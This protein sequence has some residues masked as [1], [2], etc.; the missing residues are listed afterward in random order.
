MKYEISPAWSE[1]LSAI[2]RKERVV[3]GGL[4]ESLVEDLFYLE[5][6]WRSRFLELVANLATS[7][8]WCGQ[9]PTRDEVTAWLGADLGLYQQIRDLLDAWWRPKVDPPLMLDS[10]KL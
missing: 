2:T 1:F 3:V 4:A 10:A 7:W 8:T 9:P 6:P 5:E